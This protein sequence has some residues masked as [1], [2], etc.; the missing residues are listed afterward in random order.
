MD[1]LEKRPMKYL[2]PDLF[3]E[4]TRDRLYPLDYRNKSRHGPSIVF[5][6]S[7]CRLQTIEHV[8]FDNWFHLI[9]GF[10]FGLVEGPNYDQEKCTSCIY[11]ASNLAAIQENFVGLFASR[12]LWIDFN[13]LLAAP[14]WD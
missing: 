2:N 8:D 6:E 13:D 12:V 1:E 14:F 11:I 5:G 9:R 4:D 7:N 10:F 3:P